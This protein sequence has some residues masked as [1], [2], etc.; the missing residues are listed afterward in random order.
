MRSV[1]KSTKSLR[2]QSRADL[3]HEIRVSDRGSR[4]RKECLIA[5]EVL[6]NKIV[7]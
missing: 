3:G 6:T 5:V 2:S 1:A 7:A 4:A